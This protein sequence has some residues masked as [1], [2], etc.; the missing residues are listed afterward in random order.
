MF[1]YFGSV[2]CVLVRTCLWSLVKGQRIMDVLVKG[3]DS[4]IGNIVQKII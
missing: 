3:S 1:F 4:P 2:L